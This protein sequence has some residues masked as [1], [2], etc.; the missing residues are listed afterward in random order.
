MTGPKGVQLG[1]AEAA[2]VEGIAKSEY[3]RVACADPVY[4]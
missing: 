4:V 2:S 1:L 3:F